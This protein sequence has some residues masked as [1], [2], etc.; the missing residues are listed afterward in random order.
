MKPVKHNKIPSRIKKGHYKRGVRAEYLA[1][2]YL[3]LKGYRILKNRYKTPVGEIDI[4]ARKKDTLVFVEVKTRKTMEDGLNSITH[5]SR[6]RIS[7]AARYFE[8][9][10]FEKA[11]CFEERAANPYGQTARFD[12][13]IWAGWR[14]RH[15]QNA[16]DVKL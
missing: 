12:V 15:M 3:F 16:W 9:A 7:K 5:K 6:Q 4:I 1:A 11:G 8:M 14:I 2:I 13:I 10:N